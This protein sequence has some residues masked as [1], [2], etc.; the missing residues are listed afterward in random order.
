[1]ILDLV[2]TIAIINL[3]NKDSK[4]TVFKSNG[5][6]EEDGSVAIYTANQLH[7]I[8]LQLQDSK[9]Y[10]L[11]NVRYTDL[12]TAFGKIDNYLSKL[13]DKIERNKLKISIAELEVA[14]MKTNTK[15][16]DN[17]L[18]NAIII[19]PTIYFSWMFKV[20]Y[21]IAF[22]FVLALFI[23]LNLRKKQI[24]T[25]ESIQD[26]KKLQDIYW[27]EFQEKIVTRNDLRKKIASLL[28]EG[29]YIVSDE[30]F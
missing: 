16:S 25:V 10:K 5:F 21:Y 28:L 6:L 3:Q 9:C 18:L 20:N 15:M 23:M 19:L 29:E 13:Y 26:F 7:K 4:E 8:N 17:L 1:M 24:Y 27:L 22:V 2:Q 14:S 11:Y 12:C 30:R